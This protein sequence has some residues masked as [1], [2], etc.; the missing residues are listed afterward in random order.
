MSRIDIVVP[1]VD[2]KR[3]DAATSASLASVRRADLDQQLALW[4]EQLLSPARDAMTARERYMGEAWLQSQQ[5]EDDA[6]EAGFSPVLWV[7]SAGYGLI[8]ADDEIVGYGATFSPPSED[9]AGLDPSG[10]R[11]AV[12][13]RQ[14]WK[15]LARSRALRTGRPRRLAELPPSNG[16]APVMVVAS[17]AY[18]A[19]FGTDLS[20][21][22]SH[23]QAMLV[24]AGKDLDGTA[25]DPAFDA[26]I[27]DKLAPG[28]RLSLNQRAAS[29]VVQRLG[30]GLDRD[31]IA[32]SLRDT[33]AL[34]RPKVVP[35]REV[36]TDEQ[37]KAFIRTQLDRDPTL[38]RSP[39]LRKFR[40][41]A[42]KACEQKRFGKLFEAVKQEKRENTLV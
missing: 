19:A 3:A 26:R 28:T 38:T 37:V 16:G 6:R 33:T 1:C 41:D 13:R 29:L 18:A 5:L 9:D 12:R 11:S 20:E 23:P 27:E 24:C 22:L 35:D 14:W 21:L 2:R 10:R 32:S 15:A 40:D 25:D 17:S 8:A 4:E 36:T 7:A 39:L 34:A 30:R 31:E 42:G